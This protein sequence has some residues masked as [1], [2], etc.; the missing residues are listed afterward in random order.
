MGGFLW[1]VRW[2]R[3]WRRQWWRERLRRQ[4]QAQWQT[5]WR[6]Q[7]RQWQQWQLYQ[8]LGK[9]RGQGWPQWLWF[10]AFWVAILGTIVFLVAQRW[11]SAPAAQAPDLRYAEVTPVRLPQDSRA[12]EPLPK[13]IE[14][15]LPVMEANASQFTLPGVLCGEYISDQAEFAPVQVVQAGAPPQSDRLRWVL[16]TTFTYIAPFVGTPGAAASHE[17][18]DYVHDDS[19]V[20]VVP[21]VAAAKGRV[22]YVRNGCPQSSM[23]GVNYQRREC[24]AGWGNH[25]V[26]DH[27]EGLF[28]RYAHLA[29]R[30][31][32]VRV[33]DLVE[34]GDLLGEMG[35]TGRSDT[36][37][38][39]LE[40]GGYGNFL[41]TCEPSQ[42]FE[43]V[44][45]PAALGPV[46]M[47][48]RDRDS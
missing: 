1:R 32:P 18:V 8:S 20:S 27:G 43:R 7:R 14:P 39:H 46:M 24:G 41:R 42:S 31:I 16:P 37:H 30:I 40:V 36:R 48:S 15:L 21:V 11:P 47:A 26:I 35:N 29:P 2:R 45:D 19:R 34:A 9:Q 28:T 10:S 33:G 13:S 44:Y 23:F 5:Q 3:Q 25:V 17:G 22:A 4:W 12:S 6:R 38:L